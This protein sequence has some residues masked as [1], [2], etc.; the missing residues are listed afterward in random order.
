LFANF[1]FIFTRA[2]TF[3]TTVY[4]P[5]YDDVVVKDVC[6][7]VRN[8]DAFVISACVKFNYIMF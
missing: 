6:F 5:T 4:I 2:H 3:F 8:T 1:N 7:N